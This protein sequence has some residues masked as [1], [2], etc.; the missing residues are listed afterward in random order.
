MYVVFNV[1]KDL[2]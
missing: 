1:Q 2:V